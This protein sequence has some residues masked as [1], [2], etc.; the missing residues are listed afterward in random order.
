MRPKVYVLT[1]VFNDEK[2]I[3]RSI[4]SILS[5]S[6]KY[7]QYIIIDDG[8]T[9]KSKSIIKKTINKVSQLSPAPIMR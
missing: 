6:Y 4:C 3:E 7:F 2:N 8:S 1:S 5:Q 9:D